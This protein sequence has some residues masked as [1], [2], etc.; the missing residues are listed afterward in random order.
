L[1]TTGTERLPVEGFKGLEA[2]RGE[3]A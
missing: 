1:F 3:K 2:N